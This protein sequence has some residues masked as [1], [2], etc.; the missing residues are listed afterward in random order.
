MKDID[1]VTLNYTFLCVPVLSFASFCSHYTHSRA[2]RNDRGVLVP[3]AD[4]ATLKQYGF[5]T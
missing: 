1:D 5:Q 4:E 3:E 2:R